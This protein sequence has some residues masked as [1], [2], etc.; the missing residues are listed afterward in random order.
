[1]PAHVV[2]GEEGDFHGSVA[3]H[4]GVEAAGVKKAGHC[5]EVGDFQKHGEA[6]LAQLVAPHISA[7][8]GG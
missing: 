4:S 3:Y 8:G 1:M 2:G 5:P 6:L 7:A